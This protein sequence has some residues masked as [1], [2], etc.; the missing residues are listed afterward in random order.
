MLI[1]GYQQL[2]PLYKR[3]WSKPGADAHHSSKWK[4]FVGVIY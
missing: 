4:S 3:K 2:V 1:A